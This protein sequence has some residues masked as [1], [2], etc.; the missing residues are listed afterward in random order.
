[1]PPYAICRSGE[2][3]SGRE[4]DVLRL[5]ATGKSN[6]EISTILSIST[7]TVETYRFRVMLKVNASCLVDLVHYAI[8]HQIVEL[9]T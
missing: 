9:R 5:L 6:K 7:K 4:T 1:M 8:S 2:I 3:L